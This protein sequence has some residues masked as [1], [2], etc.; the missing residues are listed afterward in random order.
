[1]HADVL[2]MVLVAL[3]DRF[4]AL[5]RPRAAASSRSLPSLGRAARSARLALL[6]A[7]ARLG[8]FV[9][10]LVVVASLGAGGWLYGYAAALAAAAAFAGALAQGAAT[11][12]AQAF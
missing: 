4:P 8:L 12:A 5:A 1:M 7:G 10:P 6:A 11:R 3:I 2:G 9:A